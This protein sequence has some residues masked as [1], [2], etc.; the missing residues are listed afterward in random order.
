MAV[1]QLL[2][3][4]A[5]PTLLSNVL[6]AYFIGLGDRQ[7]FLLLPLFLISCSATYLGGMVL[8]DYYDAEIDSH[9]RP[10]RPIPSGKISITFAF[11]LGMILLV[12]GFVVGLFC[13]L[14]S[15]VSTFNKQ[16][17][18]SLVTALFCCVV[19]YNAF[20]K[21]TAIMGS[22]SMGACRMFCY[23]FIFFTLEPS[24]SVSHIVWS[25][26]IGVYVVCVTI[27]SG[28]EADSPT[29]KRVV[30]FA[31]SFLILLDAVACLFFVGIMPALLIVVLYPVAVQLRR[32]VSMT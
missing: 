17:A 3:I 29:I 24:V 19:S 21:R 14:I 2:R 31:L 23:L 30:G 8:N 25:I 9:E 12:S 18:I 28:F 6:A 11:V 16:M 15:N 7:G 1:L 20:L 32:V 26:F 22:V 5:L 27:V 10:E 4:S 13:P